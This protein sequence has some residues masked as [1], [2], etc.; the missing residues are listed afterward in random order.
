MR[1]LESSTVVVPATTRVLATLIVVGVIGQGVLAGGF[2]GGREALRSVHELL[3]YSVLLVGLVVLV[4]GLVGRRRV[5]EPAL[6]LGNRVGLVVAT[7]VTVF[8]GMQA[9]RGVQ[10]LLMIHIPLAFLIVG[11]AIHLLVRAL[12]ADRPASLDPRAEAVRGHA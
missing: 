7:A 9:S 4:T 12:L 5:R 1:K 11:L 6:V 2:L 3:G 8:V 10:D